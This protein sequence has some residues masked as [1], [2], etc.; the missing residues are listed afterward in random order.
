[1]STKK[2][3]RPAARKSPPKGGKPYRYAGKTWWTREIPLDEHDPAFEKYLSRVYHWAYHK[4]APAGVAPLDRQDEAML[5]PTR[6]FGTLADPTNPKYHAGVAELTAV[7]N[8]WAQDMTAWAKAVREDILAIE[9]HLGMPKG[10]PGDPP[11]VP[12]K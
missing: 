5:K 7:F 9:D 12:W 10:D 8:R 11:P 3:T 6:A 4:G 2:R 1:M